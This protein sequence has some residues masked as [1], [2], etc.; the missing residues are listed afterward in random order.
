MP[1]IR[2]LMTYPPTSHNVS[3][4]WSYG[5]TSCYE[6]AF[7][8]ALSS[9]RSPLP[10]ILQGW[11]GDTRHMILFLHLCH[12]NINRVS[13]S[14]WEFPKLK[15][16]QVYYLTYIDTSQYTFLQCLID[17]TAHNLRVQNALVQKQLELEIRYTRYQ[18][19]DDLSPYIL[20]CLL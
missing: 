14:I 12:F 17:V 1:D 16:D 2:Y 8:K 13:H 19:P 10:S 6:H 20:Q 4:S 3:Y 7:T 18:T 15:F 9:S 5:L 11:D